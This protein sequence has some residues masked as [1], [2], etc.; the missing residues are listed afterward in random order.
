VRTSRRAV[1]TSAAALVLAGCGGGGPGPAA[2]GTEAAP[3]PAGG[4][5]AGAVASSVAADWGHMAG[6][7]SVGR[8][9]PA[10]AVTKPAVDVDGDGRPDTA[11]VTG[12]APDTGAVTFGV[13]T[14]SGGVLSAPFD[15]ASPVARSVLF[16]DVTGRGEVVALAD[17]GRSVQLWAVSDCQL[18]P[19]QNAQGRQYTFDLGLRTG[20]GTGVG[21][22]DAD[23][24]GTT[25]LVGLKYVADPQGPGTIQRTV[26]RLDGP[27]ARNGATDT[28]VVTR[29]GM[30]EEAQ[31]VTC[32]DLTMAADG[33]GTGP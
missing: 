1:L 24:D 23:G 30:A 19:E 26:V 28:V 5:S 32:G 29:A 8:A 7:P 21:C 33:V 9:V 14:A 12:P 17:D 2:A 25:D 10:G 4:S 15:S 6:C 11:F 27:Q 18:V 16:A 31:S 20:Y 22:V 3:P 13:R